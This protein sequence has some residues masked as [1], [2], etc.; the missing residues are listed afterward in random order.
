MRKKLASFRV[1][2]LRFGNDRIPGIGL[3]FQQKKCRPA[4]YRQNRRNAH[5]ADRHFHPVRPDLLF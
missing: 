5:D 3:V 1:L 4:H 2:A